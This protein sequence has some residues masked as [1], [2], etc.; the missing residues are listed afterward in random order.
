MD[1]GPNHWIWGLRW[2]K[3]ACY[4]SCCFWSPWIGWLGQPFTGR[5]VFSGP[6]RHPWKT[7]TLLMIWSYYHTEYRDKTRALKVHVQGAKVGLKTNTTRQS[8][9]VLVPN[10]AMVCRLQRGG[11][12]HITWEHFKQEGWHWEALPVMNC[13]ARLVFAMLRPIWRSTALTTKTKLRVFGSNVKAVLFY[14]SETWRLTKRLEQKLQVFIN[15]R[16]RNILW[17]WWPRK[18][19][20]KELWRQTRQFVSCWHPCFF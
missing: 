13:K 2:D 11:W 20:N 7:S 17:I 15:K 6:L 14:G 19:S 10:V 3:A 5:E 12:V 9:D 8:W 18:I 4:L 16:L 1:R